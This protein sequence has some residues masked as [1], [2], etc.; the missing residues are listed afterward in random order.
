IERRLLEIVEVHGRD[1]VAVYLGNPSVHSL[2]LSIYS[3]V[4]LRALGSRSGYSASTVDQMP[5]QG[6]AGLL[7]ATMPSVPGPAGD[8]TDFLLMLGANPM[9]SNGSRMTAPDLPRRLRAIGERGGKLVVVDP[10]RTRTAAIAQAYH[11][12]RPGTDAFFLA[13]LVHTLFAEGLVR[14]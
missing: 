7:F 8:R 5:K 2:G 9:E 12:I 4:F 1:A 10:R 6:A 3:Q 13:A 14:P 11:A